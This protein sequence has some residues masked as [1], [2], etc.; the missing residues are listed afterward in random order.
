MLHCEAFA[1]HHCRHASN[2]NWLCETSRCAIT[3]N[4]YEHTCYRFTFMADNNKLSLHTLPVQLVH[5]IF[6]NLDDFDILFA[7][8]NVCTRLDT[9]V[10]NYRRYRVIPFSRYQTI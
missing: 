7:V 3:Q 6:N 4:K 1:F 8:R 2:R 5:R 9:V 10:D